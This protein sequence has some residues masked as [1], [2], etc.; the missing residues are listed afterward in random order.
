M[1]GQLT[2]PVGS[3]EGTVPLETWIARYVTPARFEGQHF[4]THSLRQADACLVMTDLRVVQGPTNLI[5]GEPGRIIPIAQAIRETVS[6][7]G[8]AAIPLGALSLPIKIGGNEMLILKQCARDYVTGGTNR[9]ALSLNNVSLMYF[10]VLQNL[11]FA[12]GKHQ[13]PPTDL[14]LAFFSIFRAFQTLHDLRE[15]DKITTDLCMLEVAQDSFHKAFAHIIKDKCDVAYTLKL[16]ETVLRRNFRH[17][18]PLSLLCPG[19]V[20][21]FLFLPLL[22][23]YL[24]D[25]TMTVSA[26]V[27]RHKEVT[28]D[29]TKEIRQES[30]GIIDA[31]KVEAVIL[32]VLLRHTGAIDVDLDTS[33]TI[34]RTIESG[35]PV[36]WSALGLLATIRADFTADPAVNAV[37]RVTRPDRIEALS[38]DASRWS[39]V[40]LDTPGTYEIEIY[41]LGTATAAKGNT[42]GRDMT[43]NVRLTLGKEPFPKAYS[44]FSISGM[45]Y[46]PTL[47]DFVYRGPCLDV[48]SPLRV[49]V[50]SDVV[51]LNEGIWS[52]PRQGQPVA[53][54][55]KFARLAIRFQDDATDSI[56]GLRQ[57]LEQK[58]S[59][60]VRV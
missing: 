44:G 1:A 22:N 3:V 34:L 33:S 59:L 8:V 26:V 42:L 45:L 53:V 28:S 19:P 14:L 40:T 30:E 31:D 35:H 20:V 48:A 58:L 2:G 36:D 15:V 23:Q 57:S 12:I 13:T 6:K 10:N 17:A 51:S 49:V 60:G 25:K 47:G 50:T 54:V 27:Q 41:P 39:V 24:K 37:V 55:S 43:A 9:G 18:T 38:R 7:H 29:Y 32:R 46:D 11:A 16:V 56:Q 21:I 4:V 5:F 52:V